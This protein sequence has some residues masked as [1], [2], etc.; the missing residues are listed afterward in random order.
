MELSANCVCIQCPNR[1]VATRLRMRL[2]KY[3]IFSKMVPIVSGFVAVACLT[4]RQK[5]TTRT[6]KRKNTRITL[7]L[8]TEV[9]K[10]KS[11]NSGVNELT[12][13]TSWREKMH[14]QK[15]SWCILG[16]LWIFNEDFQNLWCTHF[17]KYWHT[18]KSLSVISLVF[19]WNSFF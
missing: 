1:T 12:F 11:V 18:F 5:E 19:N 17:Y 8:Q 14:F 4:N 10:F 15:S 2:K 9:L 7:K 6:L 3:A 16:R 13:V